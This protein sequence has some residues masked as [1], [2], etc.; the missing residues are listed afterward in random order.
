[1]KYIDLHCDTLMMFAGEHGNLY[2]NTKSVDLLRLRKGDCLAQFF[3]IWMPDGEGREELRKAGFCDA[4]SGELSDEEWDDA[5]IERLFACFQR[6]CTE[7]GNEVSLALGEKDLRENEERG[8]LSAFLTLEDGRAVRGSLDRLKEFYDKGIRLIT[9]TWNF[10]NCFGRAN[11][12][13]GKFGGRGSGLTEF[14]REAV[15]Y[16]NELGMMVDVSHLSDEGFYE[17]AA[18]SRKPFIASHS[19]ART[20]SYC[21]RNLSDDMIRRLAQKGGVTG[22]NF[23][24]G[25]LAEDFDSKE[26]SIKRM[27]AH[28][29][30]IVNCGGE[31]V[32]ALGSDLDGIEGNLEIASPDQMELLWD[33]LQKAGFTK[34]QIE[35]AARENAKRVIREILG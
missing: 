32:L 9:L 1:M 24:P 3:A 4:L 35:L 21:S 17:V 27:A 29:K 16:M 7:Y 11:Y 14:G 2:E 12:R 25:F 30:H 26:S 22:L 15:Q 13:D 34:R 18:V 20:L 5:Y 8:K 31:E 6:T 19:N 33:A 10:D 28:A 23:A